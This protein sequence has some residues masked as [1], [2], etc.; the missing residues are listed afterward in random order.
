MAQE[1]WAERTAV[2][3]GDLVRE[4]SLALRERREE[5]SEVVVEETGKAEALALGE[6]DAAIELGLFV[7]G[8]GRRYY[9]RTTTASMPHRTVMAVR[10]PVGVAGLLISFNTPLP[11]VA[12]K[13]FPAIFC[14]NGT[15]LKPSEETPLSAQLFARVCHE[16]GV[17][18]GVLN[19]VQGLGAEAG[20]ALVEHPQVDLVSFTGSAATGRWIAE[21]AGRRL[22]KVCLELG[23][24][25]ALVVCDDA[26]L[27]NA[28]R[29]AVQSS[30][31]NAGQRCAA[32]SRIVIF[33]AVYD[34][35]R[36]RFVEAAQ[37]FADTGPVISEASLGRILD[38]L[39]RAREAGARVLCGGERLERDGWWLAPT[40]LEDVAADA[41]LSCTEL[42]GPVTILY[43]VHDLADSLTVVNDS[44]YGLTC[45]VH[46]ASLHRAMR[47]AEKAE[48]GVVV[49]N[50]G[51]HGS[52]P[53]MGFGGVK[54]SGTGWREPGVEALDVYSEWKYVNLISDPA[55]I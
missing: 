9:G 20:A 50:G 21:A 24:K 46:T 48:A 28:V 4:I 37:E 1:P 32:A 33:D 40:I 25:N 11:N 47:F 3:R 8:E 45:A 53:H 31:S 2:E 29:W 44:P 23:G 52:E 5:L 35:F 41:E 26:D 30:F 51:T 36:S 13:V 7:A 15:V 39:A 34:E 12:W 55:K 14:G 27:D 6:T 42:F 19:V 54:Q 38:A 43:R 16:V 10:Q 22:A 49:V 17:P 18:A